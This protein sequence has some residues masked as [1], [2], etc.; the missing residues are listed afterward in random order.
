MRSLSFSGTI[1][2]LIATFS[3]TGCVGYIHTIGPG[4]ETLTINGRTQVD[5]GEVCGN[6]LKDGVAITGRTATFVF[7]YKLDGL[8]RVERLRA[9]LDSSGH[10]CASVY[11]PRLVALEELDI[12]SARVEVAGEGSGAGI[13]VDVRSKGVTFDFEINSQSS[14]A[15][16]VGLGRY[17]LRQALGGNRTAELDPRAVSPNQGKDLRFEGEQRHDRTGESSAAVAI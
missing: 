10:G 13:L 15:D 8:S 16:P 6:V 9:R 4:G 11:F 2:P 14:F 12:E 1:L 5:S 3:L 7:R 17:L